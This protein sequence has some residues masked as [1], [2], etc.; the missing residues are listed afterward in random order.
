MCVLLC[1]LV[2]PDG[3]VEYSRPL[4]CEPQQQ[5]WHAVS[6]RGD[7]GIPFERMKAAAQQQRESMYACSC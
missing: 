5:Q 3:G 2:V 1:V 6:A 7:C 4:V